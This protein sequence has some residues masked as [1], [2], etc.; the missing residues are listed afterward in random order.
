M[1]GFSDDRQLSQKLTHQLLSKFTVFFPKLDKSSY[2]CLDKSPS[3]DTTKE[4]HTCLKQRKPFSLGSSMKIEQHRAKFLGANGMG[5]RF[6]FITAVDAF[7]A[8]NRAKIEPP[9][10]QKCPF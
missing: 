10:G 1:G 3:Y 7:H 2:F 9:S 4:G 8:L 6:S 5:T